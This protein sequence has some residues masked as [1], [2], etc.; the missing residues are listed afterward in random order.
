MKPNTFEYWAAENL[1]QEPWL[2]L[3]PKTSKD[4]ASESSSNYE[5]FE[6]YRNLKPFER[7]LQRTAQIRGKSTSL[8]ERLCSRYWWVP[9]TSAWD[10]HL[11]E[12][13]AAAL[14]TAHEKAAEKLAVRWAAFGETA[15][16]QLVQLNEAILRL[17]ARPLLRVKTVKKALA[18]PRTED[19]ARETTTTVNPAIDILRAMHAQVLLAQL[20]FHDLRFDEDGSTGNLSDKVVAGEARLMWPAPE[21]PSEL[22]EP[23]PEPPSKL[24]DPKDEE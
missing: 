19:D 5:D 23:I 18:N 20:C 24:P 10:R 2:R 12:K 7:S 15:Y 6:A 16:Q 9:R 1:T 3:P 22:P 14:I 11:A 13:A 4:G 8:I 21:P 17:T